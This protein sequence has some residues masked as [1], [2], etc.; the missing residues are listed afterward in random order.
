V[1]K[2][3]FDVM[4]VG[5][6]PNGLA[7]AAYLSRAGARVLVLERRFEWGGTLMSDNYST[8]FLWNPAQFI[9]PFAEA[10]PPYSDF[11]LAEVGVRFI[12]PAVVMSCALPGDKRAAVIC[13]GGE[14]I[15]KDLLVRLRAVSEVVAPLLYR[16][17]QPLDQIETSLSASHTGRL[18]LECSRLTPDELQARAGGPAVGSMVRYLCGLSGFFA[19][20]HPLGLLGAFAVARLLDPVIVRGGS[21]VL[22]NALF[23]IGVA[24]GGQYRAVADVRQIAPLGSD[25]EVS[26]ADGRQ[27]RGRTVVSTLDPLSTLDLVRGLPVPPPIVGKLEGWRLEPAAFFTAHFGI[28]GVPP[29]LPGALASEALMHLVGF[30]N[31]AH[32]AE[33]FATTAR[34][35]LPEE[36][37]GHFTVTSLHDPLQASAGPYGPLHTVRFQT[38]VP[39]TPSGTSWDKERIAYRHL[40]WDSLVR[41]TVGLDESRLLFEFAES[42]TDLERRFRTTR[43]GS[44]RQGDLSPDQSFIN[45]PHPD[46]SAT[47]TPVPGLYFGGGSVHPGIP[48]SLAG[49]YNAASAVCHDLGLNR[50]WPEPAPLY[51]Q[52]ARIPVV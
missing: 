26:C 20:D 38:A 9:L 50:W 27:F 6:G 34:G 39:P 30:N 22:A 2:E 23:R 11:A 43:R 18:A 40:C 48:G 21:K 25:Y 36:V 41:H 49:G 31:G 33:L 29:R 7:C 3:T 47:R 14:G 13:R 51:G 52:D 4:V 44:L 45:R 10:L 5:G 16:A 1:D 19:G 42:P 17:P 12:K 46:C 15:A 35:E 32:V 24:V 8:P 28:K 37:S